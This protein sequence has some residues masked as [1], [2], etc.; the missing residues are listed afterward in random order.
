MRRHAPR[1][2]ALRLP[3]IA[4]A[5]G[6]MTPAVPVEAQSG[7]VA[8][9]GFH[10]GFA[11]SGVSL[12]ATMQKTVDNTASNTLVPE[13]RRGRVFHDEVSGNS[14]A[15]GMGA[16]A[17]YRLPLPG[18]SLFL[19]AE[20][21]AQW[22]GGSTEAQFA[23]VGVSPERKQ[24]G[25]SWPDTW[26]LAKDMS[27]GAT[28][29][30]GGSPGGLASRRVNL[31]LLAGVRFTAAAFTNSYH[32]CFS[33]D[34]CRPAEFGSGTEDRD[35]DFT[36]WKSGVGLEKLIGGGTA[37]RAEVSYSVFVQEDWVTPFDDVGVTVYSSMKAREVG[38]ALGLVWRPR[39]PG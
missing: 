22:H 20:I 18:G 25:E 38:L 16:V 2:L 36:V 27:Y 29:R 37:I 34:P 10:F 5:A 28:V 7:G 14:F 30:F 6:L 31:Y 32:G 1:R 17:G 35:F 11:L 24:L 8:S 19:D 21:G 3:G 33:P 13:P 4:L 23:G 12:G 15:Y 26:N 9:G 39:A